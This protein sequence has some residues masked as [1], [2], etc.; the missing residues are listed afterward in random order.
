MP[1]LGV[2]LGDRGLVPLMDMI[3]SAGDCARPVAEAIWALFG[4]GGGR[5]ELRL[6]AG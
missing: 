1:A 2:A 4:L 5:I 6:V 3:D